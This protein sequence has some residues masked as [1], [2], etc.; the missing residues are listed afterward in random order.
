MR[1]LITG[2]TGLLGYKLVTGCLRQGLEV[3]ATYLSHLPPQEF[4]DKEV[5][6]KLNITDAH[7]TGAVIAKIRPEIVINAAAMLNTDL[8]E[9]EREAAWKVN[10]EGAKNVAEACSKSD[11]YMIHLS[12]SYIFDGKKGQ[13]NEEAIPSPINHYGYTKLKGEEFVKNSGC[14][15]CIVRT[16]VVFGWERPHRPNFAMWV[17]RSLEKKEQIKIATDQYNSPTLNTSLADMIIE[18]ARKKLEGVI[19]LAG[20]TRISRL[21]FA[22]KICEVFSMD[23]KLI[24]PVK[25][26]EMDLKARR[27]RDSSLNVKKAQMILS[28]KPISIDDALKTLK[29]ERKSI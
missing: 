17:I 27:P 14:E 9:V 12:T 26:D 16:D 8:C 18:T 7:S 6:L 24:R 15:F 2:G 10:A 5:F 11:I 19:N 23:K 20:S 1:I 29:R 28:D 25:S 3:H 4:E 13:Y 21:D 22:N